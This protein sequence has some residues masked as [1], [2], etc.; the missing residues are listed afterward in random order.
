MGEFH[1]GHIWPLGWVTIRSD[2]IGYRPINYHSHRSNIW[3][4]FPLRKIN[5][6]T[7]NVPYFFDLIY[8]FSL[9]LF[10]KKPYAIIFRKIT[11]YFRA[12]KA[13]MYEM[14]LLLRYEISWH[15]KQI[16]YVPLMKRNLNGTI[17]KYMHRFMWRLAVL[18]YPFSRFHLSPNIDLWPSWKSSSLSILKIL[19]EL[20]S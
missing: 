18:F 11:N 5:F 3:I 20:N 17:R 14:S 15:R 9:R 2:N 8:H 19:G 12:N 4:M 13:S 6:A 16:M 7:K 10:Q 1:L